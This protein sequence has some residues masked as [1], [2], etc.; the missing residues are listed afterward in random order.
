M[1]VG[2]VLFSGGGGVECGM[3]LAGIRPVLGV[4]LDPFDKRL[5]EGFKRI[6]ELNGWTG[7]RSQTVED[8]VDWGCPGLTPDSKQAHKA[9][10]GHFSPV[11]ADFSAAKSGVPSHGNMQMATACM[12]AVEIGMPENFSME[13]V[14]LYQ[15]SPEFAFIKQ[16]AIALGYTFH[17]KVLNISAQFGQS[18]QR[19]IAT[20]SRVG[21][22]RSP[23]QAPARSWYDII[24]DLIPAFEE[25]T[26]TPR[27]IASARL[28]YSKNPTLQ[29]SPLY[30]E[31]VTSGTD[32][33]ARG[34]Y[35]LIP[36]LMKSKFRGG[37][38]NGRSKVSCL[39]L[40]GDR[41]WLNFTLEAYARL[42]GFPDTYRYPN[43]YNVAGS[44][45]GYAVPPLFYAQLL[46][47]M[48]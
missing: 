9:R 14:P 36:T 8:F 21:E 33:K 38:K 35:E 26:P 19:L 44:G 46:K 2:W 31:R 23:L 12:A 43:N 4:E 15:R 24:A 5:S 17:H 39:Y 25:I 48:P 6:H 18:R 30:V 11:C 29:D 41:V 10:V 28:W 1:E 45:F 27:Q 22:W 40:P 34:R 42:S 13:Q 20:A 16:R 32:P 47:I 37:S 3:E 7:L